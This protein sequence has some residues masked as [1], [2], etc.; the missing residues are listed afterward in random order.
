MDQVVV[1]NE[2][3]GL[4]AISP[5]GDLAVAAILRGSNASRRAFYNRNGAIDLPADRDGKRVTKVQEIE[6]GGFVCLEAVLFTPDGRYLYVGKIAHD[7]DL[8]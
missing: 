8:V 6:V 2:P 5:R 7:G 1:G 3:E 4:I